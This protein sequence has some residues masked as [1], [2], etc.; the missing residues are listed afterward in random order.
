[1]TDVAP[2][3]LGSTV[4][5]PSTSRADGGL[6]RIYMM[7]LA[8]SRGRPPTALL[9]WIGDLGFDTLLLALPPHFGTAD[10]GVPPP[11]VSAAAESGLR[12]QLD[13]RLDIASDDAPIFRYHP[14]WFDATRRRVADPREAPVSQVRLRDRQISAEVGNFV[15]YWAGTL[16]RWGENGIRGYRCKPDVT[17]SAA[18][19]R[20]LI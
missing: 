19:W 18:L 12:V 13:L 4:P 5:Q 14:D 11:I 7:N 1:M 2:S 20:E 10:V 9:A 17:V 6:R 16:R 3:A 15:E 8:R